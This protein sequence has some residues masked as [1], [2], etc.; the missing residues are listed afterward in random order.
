MSCSMHFE[1]LVQLCVALKIRK[2]Y[3][4]T[5]YDIKSALWI[6]IMLRCR[7]NQQEYGSFEGRLYL[8][9]RI[10]NEY[11]NVYTE[12]PKLQA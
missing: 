8:G 10:Y 7:V 3:W 11:Y 5:E 9:C 4:K 1:G 2:G 12:S 6:L